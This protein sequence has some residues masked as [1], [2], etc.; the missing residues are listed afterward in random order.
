VLEAGSVLAGP[1]AGALLQRL[2]AEVMKIESPAGGDP[3][4]HWGVNDSPH[5]VQFNAGK[6]SLAL[7]L[8]DARG[9]DAVK[10]LLRTVDVFLHNSRPGRMERL[11]LD[12]RTCLAV[13]ERLVW[14]GLTGF[15][16]AGPLASRPAYDT[17]A[18]SAAGLLDALT[19][20]GTRPSIGPALGDMAS[21]LVAAMGAVIGL[22]SRERT[23]RGL[24]VETSMLEALV[25]LTAEVFTQYVATGETLRNDDRSAI[26]QVLMAPGRDGRYLAVHLSTSEKFFRNLLAVVERDEL[27]SDPRFVAYRD[28]MANF[29]ELRAEL[30]P[31]FASR[32]VAEW[33][34]LL[35][36]ADV[37]SS[38]V[39][40]A[41]EV[42]HHPQVS[43]MGLFKDVGD[44]VA[45]FRAPWVFD[46]TRPDVVGAV[47]RLGEHSREV[48]GAALSGEEIEALIGDG[49]VRAHA[50]GDPGPGGAA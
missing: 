49:V 1:Y 4:R 19:P 46:G 22:V 47:P 42:F 25:A 16:T 39:L 44:A 43:G 28:R 3:Y 8:G 50:A 15:G 32:D 38:V 7:D 14:V 27:A 2:G 12:S 6:K 40:S 24:A 20:E 11:G 17:I 21:G 33:A 18:Q 37:P 41:G 30:E 36:G 26:S 35:A 23:G 31:L 29:A 48:L 45:L 34:A 10:Q 13:N 9:I 5:F